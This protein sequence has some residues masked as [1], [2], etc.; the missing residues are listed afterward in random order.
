MRFV[1][2]YMC[3]PAACHLSTVPLLWYSPGFQQYM[4]ICTSPAATV[5]GEAA[6]FIATACTSIWPSSQATVVVCRHP[7]ERAA[8]FMRQCIS[9]CPLNVS[10]VRVPL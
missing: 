5:T 7:G 4:G 6:P 9:G 2:A 1:L 3:G 8:S 10:P